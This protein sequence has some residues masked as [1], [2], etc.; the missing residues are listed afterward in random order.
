MKKIILTAGLL[1]ATV[2]IAQRPAQPNF[3]IILADD[4]G[5]QDLKC[6]DIDAQSV[7]ETPYIDQL[8]TEGIRFT[9]GYS[10]APTCAPSRCGI[11]SGKYPARIDKTH[12]EGGECPKPYRTDTY[13]LIEPYY[14]A[15]LELD[16]ISIPEALAPEGYFSGHIGKW[17]MAVS[18]NSFPQPIDQGFDWSRH[19]RGITSGMD[20]RSTGFATTN[21]TDSYQLDENGFAYDQTTEDALDFLTEASSTNKP[22]FCYYATWLV[23]TPI[24]IRTE[25]L[26]QKYCTKMGISYPLDG[27]EITNPGQ[28]NPYYAAMVETLDYS[29]H[30]IVEFLKTT[31]DPRWPGHK[32]IENTYVFF[33]SD[34]GGCEN[35][36]AEVIT[37]NYPLDQGKKHAEEGGTRVPFIVVGPDVPTNQVSDVM[38]NGLDFYPTM[39]S[40]AGID[41]PDRLDGEDISGLITNSVA[42]ARDTMYWHYP[43]GIAMH[44]TIRKGGWKLFREYDFIDNP[45]MN[46]FRL[47][48]LYDTNGIRNDIEE[49][50][51]LINVETNIASQLAAELDSW[52]VEV[53]ASFPHYNPAYTGTLTN[54]E[55]VPVVLD[56]GNSNG[57]A[58]VTFSGTVERAELIYTPN[59]DGSV[60][61]EW[62]DLPATLSTG[63]AEAVIPDGT[64]HYVFNLIDTNNFLVSSVDVGQRIDG[65]PDSTV[66]PPYIREP[67]AQASIT[68]AGTVFPS[69]EVWVGN[70]A[71]GITGVTI[72][73]I[74]DTN[75]VKKAGGQTFTVTQDT[76]L[77]GLTLQSGVDRTFGV[78]GTN[79]W[80][81]WIGTCTNGVPGIANAD[82]LVYESIDVSGLTFDALNYYTIDFTDTV[83]PP[84]TYAFQ[85]AWS[86]TAADHDI[87]W[88]RAGGDG[89]YTD[90][91]RLYKSGDS[92][93]ILPF[94]DTSLDED[95]DVVFALHGAVEL[96]VDTAAS[97]YKR[98]AD[99]NWNILAGW[100]DN[101]SGSYVTSTN[102][103]GSLDT[104]LVNNNRTLDLDV[105]T[106]V[107]AVRL[108]NNSNDAQ[109]NINSG[110]VLM[111]DALTVGDVDDSGIGTCRLAGGTLEMPELVTVHTGSLLSVESGTL[112]ATFSGETRTLTGPGALRISS[113][114]VS[115]SGGATDRIYLNTALTEVS[116]GSVTL[117]GQV[118]M[119]TSGSAEL[120]IIGD[121]A[122]VNLTTLNQQSGAAPGGTFRF[123]LDETGVSPVL[124]SSWIHL[125]A[126]TL[127]V[128]G[129]A[130][131]GDAT[132]MLLF[133]SV[134]LASTVDPGNIS[135]TG[136]DGLNAEVVQDQTDGNDWVLLVLTA[137]GG[138]DAWAASNGLSGAD[139]DMNADPDG[140]GRDNLM[141]YATGDGF[142]NIGKSSN[143]VE[144]VYHRRHDDT[145]S[146]TLEATSNLVSTAWDTNGIVPVGAGQVNG[147]FDAVT[148]RILYDKSGAVR[149]TVEATE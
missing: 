134:N 133:D 67:F 3:L 91:A 2:A 32:L 47:Y 58:W 60:D 113:G 48:Q 145:L 46:E 83:F 13:R 26:L 139:A 120:K 80:V 118:R 85:I 129:T 30:R 131:T 23:H 141:E 50:V 15:R 111:T 39:L 106:A 18:H 127:I 105:T 53:D 110:G 77:T 104:V 130:Y 103:P 98:D 45:D 136:F 149:L 92:T 109:L 44:S 54:K 9:Q 119:G 117:A 61:E 37:D 70:S 96:P 101:L 57:T 86:S 125:E 22:F 95:L 128:D 75:A 142:P 35:D 144:V 76:R 51:D 1:S 124:S 24:Q 64:T 72:I 78:S 66:V 74:D 88:Q 27:S 25:S 100:S 97:T 143:G 29:V 16:E 147:E 122:S 99:G 93:L 49:A 19:D 79:E 38:V 28:N 33:T 36:G 40:L 21:A 140:N 55:S 90:G 10:P 108:V 126:A 63:R 14:S 132:N 115:L 68:N 56:D 89:T 62:F 59:G 73:D 20:D 65:T 5:W 87:R 52:L 8:A 34:N 81:L 7:F 17:H 69:D 116:G 41:I 12:V 42:P 84:G 94:T 11:M 4:L 112:T 123:V 114:T 137:P 107:T 146:Y 148:N 135:I 102:L 31:D 82:T 138:Y 121:D 6:Y 71:G 43:H